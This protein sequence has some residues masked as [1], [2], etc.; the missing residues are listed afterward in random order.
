M[1]GVEGSVGRLRLTQTHYY[2]KIDNKNLLYSTENSTEDSVM[3]Y[4]GK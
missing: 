4:M 2:C 1:V 3:T